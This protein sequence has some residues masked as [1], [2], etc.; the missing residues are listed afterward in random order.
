MDDQK[1]G[2]LDEKLYQLIASWQT[3]SMAEAFRP[4]GEDYRGRDPNQV[5]PQHLERRRPPETLATI[6]KVAT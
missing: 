3:Q 4:G 5:G 2:E 1:R 6:T